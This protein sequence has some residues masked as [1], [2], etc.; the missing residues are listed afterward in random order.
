MGV[1]GT[2]YSQSQE[3]KETV[4]ISHGRYELVD[5]LILPSLK[6]VEY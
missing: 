1:D 5:V 2:K 6:S 4:E 3:R